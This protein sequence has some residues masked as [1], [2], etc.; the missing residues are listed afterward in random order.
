MRVLGT[1]DEEGIGGGDAVA[2][3]AHGRR[4]WLDV[5]VGL[6]WGR[7]PRPSYRNTSIPAGPED[8]AAARKRAAFE[9]VVRKLPGMARTFTVDLLGA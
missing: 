2:Q 4:K 9:E 8:R 3:I 1:G 5:E 6:K 7:V